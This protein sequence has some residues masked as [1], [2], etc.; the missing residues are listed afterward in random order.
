M[1]CAVVFGAGGGIGC[2]LADRLT[3][4]GASHL[5]MWVRVALCLLILFVFLSRMI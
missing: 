2:A 1:T 3:A 4:S 5:S